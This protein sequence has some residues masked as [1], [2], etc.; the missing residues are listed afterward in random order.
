[1][2]MVGSQITMVNND[3]ASISNQTHD[4][5]R[6]NS[7]VPI[8]KNL[9][10]IQLENVSK[11]YRTLAGDFTALDKISSEIFPGEFVSVIGKSGSGKSTLVNM[12]TGID[13]PTQGIVRVLGKNIH[14][15]SESEMSIWRGQHLGI[16]FQ[17]FQLLPM[18]TVIENIL[19]PMDF[20]NLIP[21]D[22]RIARAKMLLQLVEI[23][24]IAEK[25]PGAIS[26]GQQQSAAI[27]RSLANDPP[28]IIA[29]EPTGNLDT[30]AARSIFKIF[31]QLAESG[32]TIL[33]VTHDPGLARQSSRILL[34]SDGQLVSPDS[35]SYQQLISN[36][37]GSNSL[38]H[39]NG[40]PQ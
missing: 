27:A 28:I 14:V 32:K 7:P 30:L 17:F 37:I 26:G 11:I 39:D 13:H 10:I 34:L 20:A 19:L 35:D 33:M 40:E 6:K 25:L 38:S 8:T 31:C 2:K 4:W 5:T 3:T 22:D 29:D 23:E 15:D 9:P 12:L 24:D 18:L 1:M 36:T 16:V 21:E